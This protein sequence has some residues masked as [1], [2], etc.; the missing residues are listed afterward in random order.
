MNTSRLHDLLKMCIALLCLPFYSLHLL[1]YIMSSR[2]RKL[3][4]S[5]LDRW[6]HNCRITNQKLLLLIYFLH[7]DAAFRALYY[8]RL[9]ILGFM[10]SWI[11][12]GLKH[13]KLS[14]TMPIGEGCYLA[15]PLST[16]ITAKC[17]GRNF[18]CMQ[19]TTIGK[20]NY[21]NPTIGDNVSLGANVTII[22][23]IHI[24]NNVTIGAGSVVVKDIP[25]N[26]IAVGVPAKIIRHIN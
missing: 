13:L 26:C 15:H 6:S 24:G 7:T 14:R 25:D 1:C 20:T 3:I 19:L 16:I 8:H 12:P 4:S 9:G 5:D 22:G 18:T 10:I 21:G 23:P 2:G 17:I 11:R